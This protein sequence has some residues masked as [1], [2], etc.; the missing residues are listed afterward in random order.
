[1]THR[2][3]DSVPKAAQGDFSFPL[4]HD[5]LEGDFA[6]VDMVKTGIDAMHEASSRQQEI[7][8]RASVRGRYVRRK[9]L[10]HSRRD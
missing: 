9:P 2:I 3:N 7:D 10:H 6:T 8:F 5:G 1:M 4:N